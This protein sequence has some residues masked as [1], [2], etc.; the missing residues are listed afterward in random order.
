MRAVAV[1]AGPSGTEIEMFFLDLW[2]MLL[3]MLGEGE[4]DDDGRA[5]LDPNG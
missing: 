2:R 1:R 4:T 3:G 5:E